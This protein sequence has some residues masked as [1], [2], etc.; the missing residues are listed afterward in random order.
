M[1]TAAMAALSY[2][3]QTPDFFAIAYSDAPVGHDHEAMFIFACL[4]VWATNSGRL[5]PVGRLAQFSVEEVLLQLCCQ[6]PS[7]GKLRFRAC[8]FGHSMR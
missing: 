6:V 4:C 2:A 5:P 1:A 8:E 3:G 7:F